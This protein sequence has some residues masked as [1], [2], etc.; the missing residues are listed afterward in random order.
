MYDIEQFYHL[1][2][3]P[4]NRRIEYVYIGEL[5]IDENEWLY[6]DIKDELPFISD[7]EYINGIF[8]IKTDNKQSDMYIKYGLGISDDEGGS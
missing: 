5:D 1:L 6:D 2:S 8:Y 4:L 3:A 7:V